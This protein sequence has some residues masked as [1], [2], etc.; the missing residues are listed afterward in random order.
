MKGYGNFACGRNGGRDS[1]ALRGDLLC[2]RRQSRQNA[3]GGGSRAFTMPYPASPGPPFD[4]R[5]SHQLAMYL[6]PA[7]AKTRISY[8]APPAAAPCWLNRLMLLQELSRLA[9]SPRAA[10]PWSLRL[11]GWY[12]IRKTDMNTHLL[13]VRTCQRFRR[14]Q[15]HSGARVLRLPSPGGTSN[16]GPRP[17]DWSFQGDGVPRGRGKSKSPFP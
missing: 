17:P 9:L 14:P 3:T 11:R 10:V 15:A 13:Q 16:R 4:L 2:P 6:H 7:R 1:F 12:R 5:G 8:L